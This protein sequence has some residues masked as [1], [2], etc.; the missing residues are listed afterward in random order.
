[1]PFFLELGIILIPDVSVLY[2][3]LSN[4]KV[5]TRYISLLLPGTALRPI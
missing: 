5:M 2:K 3:I 1:M 4:F